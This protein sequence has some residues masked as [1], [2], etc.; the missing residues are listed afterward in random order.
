MSDQ[1]VVAILDEKKVIER[2]ARGPAVADL[3]TLFAT[4][5]S[6]KVQLKPE[7]PI[8]AQRRR[9]QIMLEWLA[10]HPIIDRR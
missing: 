4:P 7:D 3:D 10:A 9:E 6:D 1:P 5:P 2:P 8:D